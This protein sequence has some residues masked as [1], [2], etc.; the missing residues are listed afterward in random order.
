MLLLFIRCDCQPELAT[1]VAIELA[2]PPVVKPRVVTDAGVKRKPL[3]ASTEPQ[4]R[5]GYLGG[6]RAPPRW[7]D[8]FRLAVSARSPR[9]A[10]CF[11]GTDRPGAL[12]W[13]CSVN[14]ESGAV[15]DHELEPVGGGSEFTAWLGTEQRDCVVKVLSNPPYKLTVPKEEALPDRVSLVIEF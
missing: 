13:T 15:S 12:R 9:L 7:I 4:P 5:P 11:T 6:P 1:P 8:E 10:Q 2:G 3:V 14:P